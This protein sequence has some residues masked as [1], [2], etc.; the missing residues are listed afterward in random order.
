M[1]YLLGVVGIIIFGIIA[2]VLFGNVLDRTSDESV[3]ETK[4]VVK[5]TDY[6]N[7]TSYV[8]YTKYGEIVSNQNRKT[9]KISVSQKEAVI[10]ILDGYQETLET[11][12]T[13][14]NN[15]ESYKNFMFALDKLGF[16]NKKSTD[17]ENPTGVC[18]NG[19]TYFYKLNNSGSD[20]SNLWNSSC[21]TLGGDL[22]NNGSK[23]RELFTNQIPDYSDIVKNVSFN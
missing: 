19:Y 7:D 5:T 20:V 11:K 14:P 10:E 1:K 18:P 9:M 3:G 8:Q 2:V 13:Y 6:I 12:K 17:V 15:Y 4:K 16:T 23:I 22:G 21:K